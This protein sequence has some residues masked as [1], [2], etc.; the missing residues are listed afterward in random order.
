MIFDNVE[1]FN[2]IRAHCWPSSRHAALLVTARR[3]I[4]SIDMIQNNFSIP[5]FNDVERKEFLL[6]IVNR[7][8]YSKVELEAA[9][10]LSEHLGGMPLLVTIIGMDVRESGMPLQQYLPWYETY[11]PKVHLGVRDV[12][13]EPYYHHNI[14]SCY[15]LPFQRLSNKSQDAHELL[16]IICTLG[17]D[18]VPSTTFQSG[19]PD[20]LPQ[21]LKF[22]HDLW[23]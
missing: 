11:R 10:K 9:D 5:T 18:A 20:D 2:E 23:R 16:R 17:P 12:S 19:E 15:A 7:E 6:S 14:H 3:E 22:C 4:V 13:L 21:G 1:N 8:Q